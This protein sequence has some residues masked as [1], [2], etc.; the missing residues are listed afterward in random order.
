MQTSINKNNF[1]VMI[2]ILKD[3]KSLAILCMMS[4][5]MF[6]C[7]KDEKVNDTHYFFQLTSASK[8]NYK[9]VEAIESAYT[10]AYKLN[11]LKFTTPSFAPG[12]SAGL[13]LKACGQAEETIR[14]SSMKFEGRYVYEVKSEESVIYKKTYGINF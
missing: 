10:D 3:Y 8:G 2:R 4:L 6:S 12:T 14:L 9:E 7:E 11:G 1:V 5:F 13:I